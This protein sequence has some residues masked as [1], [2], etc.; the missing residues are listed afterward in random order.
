MVT[1]H[2]SSGPWAQLDMWSVVFQ[3]RDDNVFFCNLTSKKAKPDI[4]KNVVVLRQGRPI[5]IQDG[6]GG[7]YVIRCLWQCQQ[8]K[9]TVTCTELAI[10]AGLKW[11]KRHAAGLCLSR[12]WYSF[13][14]WFQSTGKHY[15]VEMGTDARCKGETVMVK[16]ENA[17]W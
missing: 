6:P 2:R 5:G 4:Q 7:G 14:I 17:F 16:R 3:G 10:A 11:R 8:Q 15:K 1:L 9:R 13:S 12:L